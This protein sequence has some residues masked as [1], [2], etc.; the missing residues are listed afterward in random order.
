MPCRP[1][2]CQR[3]AAQLAHPPPATPGNNNNNHIWISDELLSEAFNAYA[4]VSHSARRY[5]SN[6]PGPLEARRRAS[7][8][9]MGMAVA[10]AATGPPGG[11]FGALFGAGNGRNPG[12]S[13]WSWQPAGLRLDAPAPP[14]SES[15]GFWDWGAM[16][17]KRDA[18][19]SKQKQPA[20]YERLLEIPQTGEQLVEASRVAFGQLLRDRRK[21]ERLVEADVAGICDFLKSTAD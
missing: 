18:K 3:F 8:R 2:L 10:G 1:R 4:R 20:E 19:L 5:G 21:I 7:K 16:S 12:Q 17:S 11:D 9:R 14:S 6:V 13:G 15:S